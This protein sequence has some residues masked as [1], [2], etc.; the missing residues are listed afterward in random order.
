MNAEL[1]SV[2]AMEQRRDSIEAWL[3]QKLGA[4][5]WTLRSA[6]ADA[7]FRQYFRVQCG[8]DGPA[9]SLILMDAPPEREDIAPWLDVAQR[10][11]QA[12]LHAPQVYASDVT[13]GVILMEDLGDQWLL[14]ALRQSAQQ[15]TPLYRLGLDALLQMQQMVPV[16]GLPPYSEARLVAEL[17]LFP[18][19]FLTEHLGY[20]PTCSE[21]DEIESVFTI[22]I[23]QALQQPKVFVHRDYHSR[24]L[25]LLPANPANPLAQLGI[26]DFQDAVQGPL[27]YDLVSLLRDCYIQ[28]PEEQVR[29]WVSEYHQACVAAG[30]CQCSVETFQRWFDFMGLQRHLKV[31]GIFCRLWYRDGKAAYLN[32]LPLVLDYVLKVCASYEQTRN[33]GEWL[34][35]RCAGVDLTQARAN[36]P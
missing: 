3:D 27:T 30:L 12:G 33:F 32:D 14:S 19:W 35:Q 36:T 20:L 5:Q 29:G 9:G 24:N 16:D 13:L 21:W 22:T 18:K 10:L 34:A 17:E 28:W 15:V 7:S 2:T 31:L 4:G 8:P 11:G 26:I 25:L 6:S 23:N 1:A